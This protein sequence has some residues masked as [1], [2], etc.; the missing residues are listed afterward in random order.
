MQASEPHGAEITT[1]C[2]ENVY[3]AI[4][5][6]GV[7]Q[8][9]QMCWKAWSIGTFNFQIGNYFYE[10]ICQEVEFTLQ[11]DADADVELLYDLSTFVLGA[12]TRF[13]L[14]LDTVDLSTVDYTVE[15]TIGTTLT[16]TLSSISYFDHRWI[17]G[18]IVLVGYTITIPSLNIEEVGL[19]SVYIREEDQA[20]YFELV[21][22]AFYEAGDE[23]RFVP[24]SSIDQSQNSVEAISSFDY[25]INIVVSFSNEVIQT[26]TV[27]YFSPDDHFITGFDQSGQYNI[28]SELIIISEQAEQSFSKTANT[29]TV[30]EL[31]AELSDTLPT[32]PVVPNTRLELEVLHNFYSFDASSLQICWN[33]GDGQTDSGDAS[34]DRTS[35]T[36]PRGGLYNITCNVKS[37]NKELSLTAGP[38]SVL[39]PITNPT[40]SVQELI[41]GSDDEGSNA[42]GRFYIG[43]DE[44]NPLTGMI[45]KTGLNNLWVRTIK[46]VAYQMLF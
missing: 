26:K 44:G 19:K 3:T 20:S 33:F 16:Q 10:Q 9:L 17:S 38:I 29:I 5:N 8:K 39:F 18:G 45:K 23:V 4:S 6:G 21:M 35:V 14:R 41:V 30:V 42:R 34:L 1:M 24:V 7:A 40:I 22:N 37:K 11:Q 32:E 13:E 43:V 46:F 28:A 25:G 31:W 12:T 2:P 36:Y 15:W 27:P